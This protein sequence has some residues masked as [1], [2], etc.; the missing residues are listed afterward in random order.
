MNLLAHVPTGLLTLPATL[1]TAAAPAGTPAAP[2]VPAAP[3]GARPPEWLVF[4]SNF[5]P[6]ILGLIVIYLILFLPKRKQEKERRDMVAKIK[7]ND[8]VLTYGGIK[9]TVLDVRPDEHEVVLKVDEGTNTK[10]RFDL[11]AV[12]KV[13]SAA[14]EKNGKAEAKK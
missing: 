10:I 12:H 3:A 13:T 9:G 4:L 1:L 8:R 14:A 6:I 11:S 7:R 5:G 2:G